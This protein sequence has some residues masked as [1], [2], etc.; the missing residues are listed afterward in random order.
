M[1][2]LNDKSLG[3][4]LYRQRLYIYD[5]QGNYDVSMLDY[6]TRRKITVIIDEDEE[7]EEDDEEDEED[8]EE[9][10][11][12]LRAR[13]WMIKIHDEDADEDGQTVVFKRLKNEDGQ[14]A[15]FI[16]NED[17]E[18]EDEGWYDVDE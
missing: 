18:D 12:K 2:N 3:H 17:E 8:D 15:V 9:F 4:R 13:N 16:E 5:E 7:D 11:E 14:T 6:L 10:G 1:E